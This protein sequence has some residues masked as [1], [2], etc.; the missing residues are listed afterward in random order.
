[1]FNLEKAHMIM[2][3]MVANGEIVETNRGRILAP[4][5][6]FDKIEK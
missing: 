2:D 4:V 1:M 3:E 5:Q 6:L